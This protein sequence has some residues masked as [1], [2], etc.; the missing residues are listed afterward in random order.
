MGRLAAF[1]GICDFSPGPFSP[2]K[3]DAKNRLK[4]SE[5]ASQNKRNPPIFERKM[6]NSSE[7]F[8]LMFAC[9]IL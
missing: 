3:K 6:T 2:T 5:K 4:N 9:L 7:L 8:R 1:V